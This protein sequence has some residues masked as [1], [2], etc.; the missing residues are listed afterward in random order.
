VGWPACQA[1]KEPGAGVG[2]RAAAGP[3]NTL[4]AR[5]RRPGWLLPE[6]VLDF[7][8][9]VLQ[10][11]LG[12]VGEAFGFEGLIAG[13]FAG[14]FLHFALGRLGV[15]LTLSAALIVLPLSLVFSCCGWHRK[16]LLAPR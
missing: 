15:F 12:L 14:A 13:R 4:S 9:D 1:R 10:V 8:A 2:A 11:A 16:P 5:P 7:L 3:G 6:G